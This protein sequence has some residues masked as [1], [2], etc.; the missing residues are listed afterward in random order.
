VSTPYQRGAAFELRVK[1]ELEDRGWLVTRSPGSRSPFDLMA[2][3]PV[4]YRL[5][6]V[7]LVQ[8]KLRGVISRAD[9]AALGRVAET[10]GCEPVLAYTMQARGAV[11]YKYL[12]NALAWVSWAP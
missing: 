10:F 1:A 9:A 7:A 11:H 4:A 8:C 2:V 6:N 3:P 12:T 5:D